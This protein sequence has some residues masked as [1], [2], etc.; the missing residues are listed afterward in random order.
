VGAEKNSPN[1]KSTL[2]KKSGDSTSIIDA[3]HTILDVEKVVSSP[4]FPKSKIDEGHRS[5][6][7]FPF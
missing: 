4:N 5:G 3:F 2:G 6:I 1:P 7:F